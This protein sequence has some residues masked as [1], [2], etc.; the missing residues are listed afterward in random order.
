MEQL[1]TLYL[2]TGFLA[3]FLILAAIICRGADQAQEVTAQ[4]DGLRYQGVLYIGRNDTPVD[5]YRH[6]GTNNCYYKMGIQWRNAN[7]GKIVAAAA[8]LNGVY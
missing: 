7:N 4:Q 6:T 2:I 1:Q 5:C 8:A 3:C